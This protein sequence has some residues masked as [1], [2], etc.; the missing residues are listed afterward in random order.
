MLG[1]GYVGGT[2]VDGQNPETSK[3]D[4]LFPFL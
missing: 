1:Y 4:D 2:T 3:D